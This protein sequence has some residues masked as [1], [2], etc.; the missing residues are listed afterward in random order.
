MQKHFN[1]GSPGNGAKVVSIYW[2]TIWPAVGRPELQGYSNLEAAIRM[3]GFRSA[4]WKGRSHLWANDGP[5]VRVEP[6]CHQRSQ[7]GKPSAWQG[8][9][10]LKEPLLCFP[11]GGGL[12]QGASANESEILR[13]GG[14]LAPSK[15]PFRASLSPPPT[16]ELPNGIKLLSSLHTSK[17]WLLAG[18]PDSVGDEE[19]VF[20]LVW[21][22]DS[23]LS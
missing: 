22:L 20:L 8:D 10:Q 13:D 18:G 16:Q 2:F 3:D 9:A 19:K 5:S 1:G 4:N 21:V 6:A 11:F 15:G 12:P 17:V 7:T 14:C 23:D